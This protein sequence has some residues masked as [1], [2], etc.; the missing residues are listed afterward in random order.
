[1]TLNWKYSSDKIWIRW[2]PIE[3]IYHIIDLASQAIQQTSL[4]FSHSSFSDFISMSY[5]LFKP[6]ML[7]ADT[8][9]RNMAER[10]DK[11]EAIT[12]K[13][14]RNKKTNEKK[15]NEWKNKKRTG[16]LK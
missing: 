4:K 13:N 7:R 1:M 15:K 8:K 11:K 9:E 6:K 12:K 5:C 3:Q 2:V 14:D 10:K 16:K